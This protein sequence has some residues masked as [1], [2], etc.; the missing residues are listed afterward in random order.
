MSLCQFYVQLDVSQITNN[1]LLI[2]INNKHQ[3]KAKLLNNSKCVHLSKIF[4]AYGV[5]L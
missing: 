4:I 1:M 3:I 2:E 5:Y